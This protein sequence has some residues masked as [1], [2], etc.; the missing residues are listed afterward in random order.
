MCPLI[1]QMWCISISHNTMYPVEVN[2]AHSQDLRVKQE[3]VF[4]QHGHTRAHSITEIIC[5]IFLIVQSEALRLNITQ[6]TV[7]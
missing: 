1:E 3:T 6:V 5:T 7:T 4:Y 2:A